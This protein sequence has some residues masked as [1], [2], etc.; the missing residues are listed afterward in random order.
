MG[1]AFEQSPA[2]N[3]GSKWSWMNPF[4]VIWVGFITVIFCL[5]FTPLGGAV[6]RRVRLGST[7]NYA[8]VTVGRRCSWSSASGGR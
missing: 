7:L 6:G 8:P 1:D 2:W 5:P 4:A 3:L